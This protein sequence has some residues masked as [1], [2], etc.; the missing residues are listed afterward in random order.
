M[1]TQLILYPQYYQGFNSINFTANEFIVDDINFIT[2]DGSTSYST[3]GSIDN[4]LYT[5]PP[6]IINTWYRSQ[7]TCPSFRSE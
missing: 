1:S 5:T 7:I 4:H 3:S 2:I 6:A